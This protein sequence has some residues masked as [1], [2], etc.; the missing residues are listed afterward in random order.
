MRDLL[1]LARTPGRALDR[2]AGLS[3]LTLLVPLDAVAR[4]LRLAMRSFLLMGCV[5]MIL[6]LEVLGLMGGTF[7]IPRHECS[8]FEGRLLSRGGNYTPSAAPAQAGGAG[9]LCRPRRMTEQC[10]GEPS[11][12]PLWSGRHRR[13]QSVAVLGKR[14]VPRALHDVD[15]RR[16]PFA[17][18]GRQ[19]A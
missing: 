10:F 19:F 15:R 3:R 14:Q 4:L 5:R 18:V 11:R 16:G 13:R 8:K 1:A 7:A 12:Y 6:G 17:I 2:M 9:G